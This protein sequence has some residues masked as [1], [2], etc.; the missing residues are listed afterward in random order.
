M[1]NYLLEFRNQKLLVQALSNKIHEIEYF[2]KTGKPYKYGN[3]EEFIIDG[4]QLIE[5]YFYDYMMLQGFPNEQSQL[6]KSSDIIQLRQRLIN[7]KYLSEMAILLNLQNIINVGN[8]KSLKNNPKILSDC[9]KSIIGAHY[10]DKQN[11][12]ET[13]RDLIHPIIV[14]LLNKGEQIAKAQ[15]K[16]NPKSS[17]LEYLNS[18]KGQ[19]E[20]NPK[21]TIEWKK[22][23]SMQNSNKSIY[24]I[25]L[26]LNSTLKIQKFGIN[27]RETEQNVYLEALIQLRKYD[28]KHNQNQKTLNQQKTKIIQ[29]QDE[30][31]FL[32]SLNSTINNQDLTIH[33]FSDQNQDKYNLDCDLQF[34][35]ILEKIAFE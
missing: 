29:I 19:L 22:D 31:Q 11:D 9:L 32:T 1:F 7:D 18:L 27:K 24:Q 12:L 21:L 28:I 5:F 33:S 15:W 6:K 30:S 14:Q 4:Q 13:L 10:Y 8:Q 20:I 25:T 17:F 16:Y 2:Q 26:E 34:N 23:D 3:N 35:L